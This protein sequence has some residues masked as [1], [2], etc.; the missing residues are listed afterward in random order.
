MCPAHSHVCLLLGIMSKLTW[1]ATIIAAMAKISQNESWHLLLLIKVTLIA[2]S[3]SLA[4]QSSHARYSLFIRKNSQRCLA[5]T[6]ENNFFQ[7]RFGLPLFS[8]RKVWRGKFP[9]QI[10]LVC[11][12]VKIP[13]KKPF[14]KLPSVDEKKKAE[15]RVG[16]RTFHF[17]QYTL[18]LLSRG[19]L[20]NIAWFQFAIHFLPLPG[21]Q[22][23]QHRENEI[24]L[25]ES[26]VWEERGDILRLLKIIHNS[27]HY[28]TEL[29]LVPRQHVHC[30]RAHTKHT[31]AYV[32]FGS[33]QSDEKFVFEIFCERMKFS[34]F[35]S[36][37]STT[38]LCEHLNNRVSVS[39]K[40][41]KAGMGGKK[42]RK[43]QILLSNAMETTQN[44]RA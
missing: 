23:Q 43:S 16:R 6:R 37:S 5:S 27:W 33:L 12:L 18:W 26:W 2:S 24:T 35:I 17:K 7:S 30:R 11:F 42:E 13:S 10:L 40:L 44:I 3:V 34:N 8:R 38:S 41:P 4:P 19:K 1:K 31:K 25:V 21:Q 20:V 36:S 9:L 14:C 39:G 28:G 22:Q 32:Q 29:L 15:K